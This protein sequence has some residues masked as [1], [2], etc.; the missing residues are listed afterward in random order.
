MV[1]YE[2]MNVFLIT[3][4]AVAALLGIGVV[5]FWIIGRRHIPANAL[6]LLTSIAIDISIPCLI[7]GNILTEFSPQNYPGWW[8][9]PLWWAGFSIVAI[10]LSVGSSY[11]VKREFRGEFAMSLFFQNGIFFPL[12]IISGLFTT[13]SVASTYLI[14]LF[15]FIFLQ[16]TVVFS[17]YPLFFR[18][19]SPEA[20]LN[21]KRIINPVLIVTIIGLIFGLAG[22]QGSVPKF[23][24][25]ILTMIGAMSIALFMLILGG[26]IYNDFMTTAKESRKIYTAEVIKFTLVKNLL[27]PLVVLGLL[28]WIKP[29]YPIAFLLILQAAVPPITAVPLLAQRS[30]GNRSIANQ[31]VVGSFIFS[32]ISIPAVISLFSLYFPFPA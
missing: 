21:W 31:F 26:N 4:Q 17:A 32:I 24:I 27:F 28:V 20:A 9:M 3:F 22:I 5:G 19:S 7:L 29:D 13:A 12:I 23:I 18:K 8:H 6:A 25:M 11:L 16:P 30:G 15:L 10:I 1:Y 14:N 2:I